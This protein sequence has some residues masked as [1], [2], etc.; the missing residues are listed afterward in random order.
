MTIRDNHAEV[1]CLLHWD[2]RFA[3]MFRKTLAEYDSAG[4]P[5][6][7]LASVDFRS[8]WMKM[9][10][11]EQATWKEGK[12]LGVTLETIDRRPERPRF[13]AQGHQIID[14]MTGT[15]I[16]DAGGTGLEGWVEMA[17][18]NLNQAMGSGGRLTAEELRSAG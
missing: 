15:P 14:H 8:T 12:L 7:P 17:A 11:E 4:R 1:L 5:G 9:T 6:V 18:R 10:P 3:E 13:Y 2:E 16:L